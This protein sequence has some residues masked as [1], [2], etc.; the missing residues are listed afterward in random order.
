MEA[1]KK[2]MVRELESMPILRVRKVEEGEKVRGME[3]REREVYLLDE[4]NYVLDCFGKYLVDEANRRV[5]M[6]EEQ[7]YYLQEVEG[8]QFRH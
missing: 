8:I 4:Q 3:G 1:L 2:N 6:E 7:I 5:Q